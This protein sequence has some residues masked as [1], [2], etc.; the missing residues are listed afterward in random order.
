MIKARGVNVKMV[1]SRSFVDVL[2]GTN[3]A[4]AA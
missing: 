2:V 3:V 4:Q 1:P